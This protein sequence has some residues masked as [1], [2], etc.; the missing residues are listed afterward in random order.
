MLDQ[1]LHLSDGPGCLA[2]ARAAGGGEAAGIA[3][4]TRRSDSVAQNASTQAERE[5]ARFWAAAGRAFTALVQRDTSDALRLLLVLPDSLCPTCY[6]PRLVTAELLVARRD[7]AEGR[8]W[9][10]RDVAGIIHGPAVPVVLWEFWRARLF[11]QLGERQRAASAYQYV[12]DAWRHG[13]HAVQP[14]VAEARAGLA[15]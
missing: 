13:D 7:T 3:A 12:V 5:Q 11:D 4:C 6:L 1:W 2:L 10:S 14:W 15:R 8:R 9:L